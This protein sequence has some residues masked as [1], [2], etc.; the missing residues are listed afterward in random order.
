M[1]NSFKMCQS[2]QRKQVRDINRSKA[3]HRSYK[4]KS[5]EKK[6]VPVVFAPEDCDS[7]VSEVSFPM[8]NWRFD[9]DDD[10]TSAPPVV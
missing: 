5:A 8:A 10:A 9:D 4:K 7:E 6:G 1:A 3:G 2:I